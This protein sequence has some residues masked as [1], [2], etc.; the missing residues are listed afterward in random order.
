VPVTRRFVAGGVLGL[1]GVALMFWPEFGRAAAGASGAGVVCTAR[2]GRLS[3]VG[4][5]RGQPQPRRG[6]PFWPALGCGMLYG[7]AASASRSRGAGHAFA[8]PAVPSW[9]ASLLYLSLAGSVLTFACYLTLIDRVGA[10]PSCAIGV[11][12]A[13]GCSHWGCRW[14]SRG[15]RRMG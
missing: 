6:L 10:G 2:R 7:A 13:G 5:L 12:D 3:A 8:L 4:S 11:M 15:S 14:C 1:A 9:W